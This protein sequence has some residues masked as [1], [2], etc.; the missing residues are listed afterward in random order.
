MADFAVL[1]QNLLELSDQSIRDV[2]VEQTFIG[3]KLVHER[4]ESK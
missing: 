4:K 2:F 3:G 1:A